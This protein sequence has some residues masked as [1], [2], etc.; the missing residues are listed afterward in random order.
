M[1]KIRRELEASSSAIPDRI[2]QSEPAASANQMPKSQQSYRVMNSLK[3]I[4]IPVDF[5]T[6][7]RTA[8]E[9]AARLELL[10]VAGLH[11]LLCRGGHAAGLHASFL[12]G[13]VL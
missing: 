13:G 8:L 1:R 2:W 3:T 5:S 9:Q 10:N 7:S 4:L 11:A 6:D 12:G